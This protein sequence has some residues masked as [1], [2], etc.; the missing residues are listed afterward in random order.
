MEK[1]FKQ[2][3]SLPETKKKKLKP[4]LL[5]Y[6]LSS[7]RVVDDREFDLGP[8]LR[9]Q[10]QKELRSLRATDEMLEPLLNYIAVDKKEKAQL[11]SESLPAGLLLN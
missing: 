7:G 8:E 4:L 1:W 6:Y 2:L 10:Y 9:L 5:R 3:S 11:M